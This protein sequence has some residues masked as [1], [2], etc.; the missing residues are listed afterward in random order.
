[1][2]A[3]D[4]V[5]FSKEL[6]R[7]H[8]YAKY[9]KPPP[10]PTAVVASTATTN[11]SPQKMDFTSHYRTL[12]QVFTDEV[13]E[14]F[15][16]PHENFDTCDPLQWWAGWRSQFPNLSRLARDILSIPGTISIQLNVSSSHFVT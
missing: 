4:H 15:K 11:G 5:E 9:D 7:T 6:L 3:R 13:Q 10:V 2:D 8:F 12:P 14:Y 16:L 1:L